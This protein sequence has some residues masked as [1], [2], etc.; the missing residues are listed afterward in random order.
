LGRARSQEELNKALKVVEKSEGV[1]KV[2][3]YA[4]VRP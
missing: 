2:V 4:V 1:A 3:N